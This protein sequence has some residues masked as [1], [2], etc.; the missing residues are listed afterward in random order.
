MN[1][2]FFVV[3]ILGVLVGCSPITVCKYDFTGSGTA[4]SFYLLK[5]RQEAELYIPP[6]AN[7]E[8]LYN[9]QIKENSNY[10][11]GNYIFPGISYDFSIKLKDS[12][13]QYTYNDTITDV[14]LLKKNSHSVLRHIPFS[15]RLF[16]LPI[17]VNGEYSCNYVKDSIVFFDG[18]LP[19]DCFVF[20]VLP[21]MNNS[22]SLD[23]TQL[24]AIGLDKKS[25][26]PVFVVNNELN[27]TF[28]TTIPYGGMLSDYKETRLKKKKL[29]SILFL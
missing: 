22:A 9:H 10:S 24:I 13:V 16:N 21:V 2:V 26:V 27:A 15:E 11:D 12:T 6:Y 29:R 1:K 20:H 18:S 4:G 8:L 5:H 17:S 28:E 19:L 3:A 25:G 7:I 23:S 14:F